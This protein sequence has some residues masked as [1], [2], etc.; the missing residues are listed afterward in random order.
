MKRRMLPTEVRLVEGILMEP[1]ED[2][3]VTAVTILRAI[4]EKREAEKIRIVNLFDRDT[5]QFLSSWGPYA[6]V[7][8]A[9]ED[10]MKGG[11]VASR[12]CYAVVAYL[13]TSDTEDEYTTEEDE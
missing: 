12:N 8:A 11:V 1:E 2:A 6:S 10:I 3:T 9:N 13:I 5:G 4:N 7:K